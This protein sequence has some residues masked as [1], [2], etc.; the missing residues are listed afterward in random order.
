M[1]ST[2]KS[3]LWLVNV[4]VMIVVAV[5]VPI[6]RLNGVPYKRGF[7]C[8]DATISHPYVGSTISSRVLIGVGFGV[9][10]CLI[11]IVETLIRGISR[12]K[13]FGKEIPSYLV[14]M[15]KLIVGFLF[16]AGC[17]Q[18][19]TEVCKYTIG[20]FRPH[21]FDVCRPDWSSIDCGTDMH[22]KFI[23]NYTCLGNAELFPNEAESEARIR[24]AQLSFSSGH[25]CLSFQAMIFVILYLQARFTQRDRPST[26]I[27]VALL[28]FAAFVFAFYTS[29]SRISDYKH[30]PGDVLF[31][32][33]LGTTVQIVNVNFLMKLF[34]K[35]P[36]VP[37]T[38][39]GHQKP[40][41]LHGSSYNS[42]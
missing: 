23:T 14:S 35:E 15:I 28:Q 40:T 5:P 31:G 22:P 34:T 16:G 29:L 38:D 21:F 4:V 39:E 32:G 19:L 11:V 18:T 9:P 7:F 26:T 25:A 1:A 37:I 10:L 17:A 33:I 12:P 6:F 24:D 8:N 13:S 3:W 41:N 42:N 27:V 2:Y 36:M 20:R 30:H